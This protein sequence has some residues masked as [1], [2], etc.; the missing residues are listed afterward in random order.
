MRRRHDEGTKLVAASDWT[1]F[2]LLNLSSTSQGY[3]LDKAKDKIRQW[4]ELLDGDGQ[5]A[6]LLKETLLLGVSCW[7][8]Q[9]SGGFQCDGNDFDGSAACTILR[10]GPTGCMT[11]SRGRYRRG[12]G[13]G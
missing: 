13:L 8:D 4:G 3:I 7:S 11:I 10:N 2:V 5:R 6:L 1:R 12:S 9:K